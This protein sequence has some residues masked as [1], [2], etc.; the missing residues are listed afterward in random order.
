MVRATKRLSYYRRQTDDLLLIQDKVLRKEKK[1]QESSVCLSDMLPF[2]VSSCHH[3]NL[4]SPLKPFSLH[5]IHRITRDAGVSIATAV[6]AVAAGLWW[7][8]VAI[9]CVYE[10]ICGCI[11]V[12]VRE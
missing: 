7:D 4:F 8:L 9:M 12:F 6:Q 2:T 5:P 10:C 11:G 1:N 3:V